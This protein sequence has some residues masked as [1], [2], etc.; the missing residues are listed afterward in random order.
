VTNGKIA[1]YSLFWSL[2]IDGDGFET[3]SSWIQPV[4][5]GH[6]SAI[7]KVLKPASDEQ[8][9]AGLLAYY[10]GEGAVLLL[11]A[12]PGALLLERAEGARSL[13]DLATSGQDLEAAA[14]LADTITRL[15]A[16]RRQA[17]PAALTPLDRQF[18][19]LFDHENHSS[20]LRR[21][22]DVARGLL[23][24]KGE[25]T[26]LHGDLHH[27]NVL[28]G[29]S[30][31]WLAIDPKG[32]LGER[33]YDVANLLR[34]PWPRA[35]LVHDRDRMERLAAYYAERLGYDMHRV[36]RFAFAHAGLSAAWDIEEAEDPAYS[37][38]CAEIL[39]SLI[40]D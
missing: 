23:S 8:N 26:P 21:C 20:L 13:S 7:L 14:T 35:D 22:A 28:D 19:S 16:P 38:T 29:G 17:V 18:D 10:D 15:H 3:P 12:D 24:A 31:G 1:H 25:A 32:L 39:S 37:L 9:A 11:E 34:N 33:T 30:R 40:S 6:E 4:R 27:D 36:V 2:T 5:R